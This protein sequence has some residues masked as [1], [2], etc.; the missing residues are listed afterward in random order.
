[1]HFAQIS[2]NIVLEEQIDDHGMECDDQRDAYHE[3]EVLG[4][5]VG[6]QHGD[7]HGNSATESRKQHQSFFGHAKLD[8][9]SL[10]NDLV[11]DADDN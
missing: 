3:F 4:L 6:E 7:V 10:G 8:P 5:V 2:K 9:F 11:V 1:M